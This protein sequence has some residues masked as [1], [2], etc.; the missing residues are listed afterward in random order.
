MRRPSKNLVACREA[1]SEDLKGNVNK[2]I[3]HW[4]KQCSCYRAAEIFNNIVTPGNVKTSEHV[5]GM[6]CSY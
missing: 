5:Q 4:R 1:A 2:D 6:E 3:G